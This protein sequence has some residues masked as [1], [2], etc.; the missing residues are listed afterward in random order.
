MNRTM[1]KDYLTDKKFNAETFDDP[2]RTLNIRA[3]VNAKAIRITYPGDGKGGVVKDEAPEAFAVVSLINDMV[4]DSPT[5]NWPSKP[6]SIAAAQRV[7]NGKEPS[8][9]LWLADGKLRQILESAKLV[10]MSEDEIYR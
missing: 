7:I 8:G 2:R 6:K 3:L 1:I 4:P 9:K 5:R 10:G